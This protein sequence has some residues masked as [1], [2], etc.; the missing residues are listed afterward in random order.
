MWNMEQRWLAKIHA[1][2][3]RLCTFLE[4]NTRV[5]CEISTSSFSDK[6]PVTMP[7][8]YF[9]YFDAIIGYKNTRF[10]IFEN[11]SKVNYKIC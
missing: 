8:F 7:T 6:K 1:L 3:R 4:I 11:I 10:A 5:F 2:N 9:K